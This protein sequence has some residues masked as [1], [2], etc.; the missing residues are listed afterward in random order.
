MENS[1][2]EVRL[3]LRGPG[4]G[5]LVAPPGSGKTTVV[6]LRLLGE[7]WLADRKIVILEPRRIATRA[8]ARRM[9]FLLGEE[10]GE[11][12][13]YVTRDDR[14]TSSRTRLE[15]VTEGILTRRLQR[16]PELADT[17]LV[18]FDELHERNLQ[19]DLGMALAL[20]ARRRV[21]PDLRILAM[22]A[23]IDAAKVARLLGGGE[24]APVIESP[25]QYHPV[26]VRWAPVARRQR[27]EEHMAALVRQALAVESGSILVFLPG[28]GEIGRVLALLE[29]GFPG[30]AVLP[31]HGTLSA[32]DQDQ[33]LEPSADRRVVLSTDIAE[34]SL[35]V[36][37]VRVVIDS[38]LARAPRFDPRTG[39]TRLR[40]VSISKASA[41]QR[42]GRAGR[43]EPGVAYRGWS[44]IEHSARL[45]H[46]PPEITEVD[47]AGL[48]L[49]A[50]IWG[51]ADLA[52]LDPPPPRS[53]KEARDLLGDLGAI[54]AAGGPTDKGRRMASLPLH[55]RLAR[56]VVDA[57]GHTTLA[58]RLAALLEDRDILRGDQIPVDLRDRLLVIAGGHHPGADRRAVERV[59]RSADDLLRRLGADPT[60]VDL[61]EA[62]AVL[63]LAF[64]DRLAV[65]RGGPGKFQL[66]TGTTAWLPD[67]DALATEGY[68]VAADLDGKRKDARIRLA[69]ALD[70][71]Q[72]ASAFA[73]EVEEVVRLSWVNDR[74]VERFQRRLG[75]L[76]LDST[77]RR[78][79]PS[80][81]VTTALLKRIADRRLADL[82]WTPAAESLRQRVVFLRGRF[83]DPWP[84]WSDRGLIADLKD[85]LGP[86]LSNA[87]GLDDVTAINLESLL[88]RRLGPSS[89][90]VD[91]L[92][93]PHID[94]PSGRRVTIDY[95]GDNPVLA[96]KAQELFGMSITP[97]VAGRPVT[98]QVLSPAGRPIQVT[99]DLAGFWSGSWREVRKEMAT[100]YPKHKWPESPA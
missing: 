66:R 5:V 44:Q 35:T 17:G 62:G 40:T 23:T 80:P 24:V 2:D 22:S 41:H 12:V 79:D 54:D 7:P 61:D 70:P 65:R 27:L 11:T 100:R 93:P 25:S 57:A 14:R 97:V 56:M 15:V 46:T 74:L 89:K 51:T 16:S 94:L 49:E 20:S 31:L 26:E 95:S 83:G 88:R 42:A 69:A 38:G 63:A 68:L 92:T 81:A 60:E 90:D 39:M 43:T 47:L 91:Q 87:T 21:R 28:V 45:A 99:S 64:P 76:A 13:G 10:V 71:E 75:G 52:F 4:V 67:A 36:E 59:R 73:H 58:C 48:A 85:W 50:A 55:P 37:G 98:V 82:S 3:A 9:A 29:G 1:L 34:T 84:D 77:E 72:V 96:A 19:T 86:A 30:V 53:L 32:V 33:A 78:P 8:A 18:I 6:P